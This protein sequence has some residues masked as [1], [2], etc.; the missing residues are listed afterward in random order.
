V[1]INKWLELLDE[2]PLE[3]DG[4]TRVA[5]LLLSRQLIRHSIHVGQLDV[6]SVGRIPLHFW[7]ELEDG[8]TLD[9]RARMWLNHSATAHHGLGNPDANNLYR[10]EGT[11]DPA[12]IP[13]ILFPILTGST[14]EKFPF[15]NLSPARKVLHGL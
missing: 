6:T 11:I 3:C 15:L 10:S 4:L 14:I 5:S 8:R 1:D 9:L 13:D 2:M 12:E 7:I